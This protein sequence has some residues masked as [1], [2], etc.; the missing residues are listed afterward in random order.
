MQTSG[1][2]RAGARYPRC[3]RWMSV[4]FALTGVAWLGLSGCSRGGERTDGSVTSP[5]GSSPASLVVTPGV[6][7]LAVGE[8]ASLSAQ[9]RSASGAVMAGPIVWSSSAVAVATVIGTG[10]TATVTGVTP[11][12]AILV[13]AFTGTKREGEVPTVD[14]LV[15]YGFPHE[16]S[17]RI[18]GRPIVLRRLSADAV[19]QVLADWK[20]LGSAVHV[21]SMFGVSLTVSD[22]ALRQL[23]DEVVRSDVPVRVAG[24]M[25]EVAAERVLIELIERAELQPGAYCIDPEDLG[26]LVRR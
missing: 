10:P 13:A 19:I 6:S 12:T 11:G 23:T 7:E 18:C 1:H 25:L 17:N 20:G 24:A 2:G 4:C 8:T 26:A 15:E 3:S 9:L 22:A 16:L 5:E 14:D 21:A